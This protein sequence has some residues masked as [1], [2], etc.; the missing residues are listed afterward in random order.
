MKYLFSANKLG[1]NGQL[2]FDNVKDTKACLNNASKLDTLKQ[3][4]GNDTFSTKIQDKEMEYQALKS[5]KQMSF[6]AK[7]INLNNNCIS[8]KGIEYLKEWIERKANECTA[9]LRLA[10]L[11]NLGDKQ[12]M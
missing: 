1:R 6:S 5:N 3:D 7:T 4:W 10:A 12:K 9:F 2:Y 8:D 11:F